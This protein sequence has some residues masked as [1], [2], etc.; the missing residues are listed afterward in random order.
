MRGYILDF[1]VQ[2]NRGAISGMD[3]AR[4]KFVGEEWKENIVPSR[5]MFVDFETNN[6][7]ACSVYRVTKNITKSGS[8]KSIEPWDIFYYGVIVVAF[9]FFLF[10]SI[11][12]VLIKP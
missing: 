7:V 10:F 12:G 1:S 5:G 3:G 2:E 6:S 11:R 8:P 9:G 4:Y